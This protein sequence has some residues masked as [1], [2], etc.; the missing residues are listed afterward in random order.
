L[1]EL[2]RR[3]RTAAALS[4]EELAERAG[5]SVRAISD[6]ER[7]VHRTPRLE[8]VRL[9]V[10]A[11]G[12]GEVDRVELL[13]AARPHVM[14]SGPR[15]GA[16]SQAPGSLPV[17]L[18]RLIGRE[19]EVGAIA[20]LL[21]RDDVRL[22]T[23]TGPG[24][25]GKTRL[26]IEIGAETLD[27]Y[28]DGVFFADL[29]PLTDP[30]LVLPTI[31]ATLGVR[32]V[33]GHL[34]L[35][36]LSSF[37]A[38]KRLL[39]LLDNCERIL[40]AAPDV[41]ALLAASPT[42]SILATSRA[43]LHIRGERELP[44]LPLPLPAADLL[45]PLEEL[46][47]VPAVALFVDLASASQ[48]DFALI[49]EN[50]AAVAAICRRLDGLP[51]AIELAAARV[52]VLPPAALLARLEQRLPLLTGGGRDLPARQRTMRDAI[53]WSYDLLAPD[54]QALFR[55]L[56][57]F[58]GGFTLDAAEA[59]ATPN[60]DRSVLDGVVALVEQSL[61][62]RMPSVDQEPRYQTLE[63]VREFG[64][65]MLATAKETAVSRERHAHYFLGPNDDPTPFFPLFRAPESA[66]FLATE[67]DNVRLALSWLDEQGRMDE[68][69]S[70]TSL[71][72]R[73]WFAPGLFREG[74]HW[75]ERALERTS[76][77][78]PRLRFRALDAAQRLAQHR[79]DHVRTAA[80]ATESL[81]IAREL[82]DPLLI[83][84]A[85]IGAGHLAYRQGEYG[86]ADELLREAHDLLRECDEQGAVAI[87]LLILGDTAL[88]QEQFDRA[89]AWYAEA[90]EKSQSIGNI[91][92]LIDAQAGLGVVKVGTADLVQA[93]ALYRDSLDQAHDQGF[94]ILVSSA[95]LGLAAIAVA[96]GQPETGA[97][98]LGAAAGLAE[99]I[100]AALYP[101]DRPMR[102]RALA[103]L[104]AA[105]GEPRLAAAQQAG[106][107][108]TVD[109]AIAEAQAIAEAV[110]A[111]P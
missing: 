75:I 42:V 78:A 35:Q 52:K 1:D 71:L 104:T 5:L 28:P 63:T 57:V 40:A 13:A 29:A 24:G 14:V 68:L 108:L 6:L 82:G 53:A 2:V 80:F 88:A 83:G 72:H 109:A 4:Q 18:T 107:M 10:E 11:L 49:A 12:L 103:V 111:S 74:Q 22:V 7:G 84:V 30:T 81:A 48:P 62:R 51:L 70:R 34:L 16:R 15:Q 76:D 17:P 26:A 19:T 86:R 98:L 106:R 96:S 101:R 85:L 67:R 69:L 97:S 93:A 8:T 46:A 60:E 38:D 44:L 20:Q 65:E 32:E 99:S 100:G 55:R 58:A 25:T 9:V 66:A 77:A 89:A 64:L 94:T 33:V 91:W 43:A 90:I 95:L 47:Q 54:E 102:D 31:A 36:T 61:L 73:L 27:Q 23:L 41:G 3:H 45:P 92:V 39:L 105:P 79:G 50:A 21:A 37:L 110:M 59:V 87:A 56:A